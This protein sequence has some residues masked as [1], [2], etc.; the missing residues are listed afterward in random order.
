MA[1]PSLLTY[2]SWGIYRRRKVFE[3]RGREIQR[4]REEKRETEMP[5]VLFSLQDDRYFP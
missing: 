2:V 5:S 1:Q 3:V 4:G